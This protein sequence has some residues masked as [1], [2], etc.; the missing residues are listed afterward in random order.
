MAK[1]SKKNP[2]PGVPETDE[3][4]R[5]FFENMEDAG[6]FACVEGVV[7]A[8]LDRGEEGLFRVVEAEEVAILGEELADRYLALPHGEL[9]GGEL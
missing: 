9:F 7:N 1:I 5:F 6:L 8:L 4:K 3:I 2:R